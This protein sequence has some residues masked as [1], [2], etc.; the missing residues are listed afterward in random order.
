MSEH[1]LNVGD[2]IPHVEITDSAGQHISSEQWENHFLV[3][4]FYPKDDTPGCTQEACSF[5]D[6]LA[7]LTQQGALVIGV[8]PDG[9]TAHKK[10]KDKYSLNFH[11]IADEN[12]EL[13]ALFG[14]KKGIFGIT[15]TTFLVDP[16]G[17]IRWIERPVKVAG[18]V[19][20]TLKAL[21]SLKK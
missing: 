20:R 16:K 17:I 9:P 10:F 2:S 3:L 7:Q 11:L 5:R 13:C 15:R 6:N 14:V 21:A 1:L 4:Y 12:R 19:E 8:S 18:H